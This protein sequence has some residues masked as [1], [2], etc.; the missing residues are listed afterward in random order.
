MTS[1][2]SA[3]PS[4]SASW[5]ERAANLFP[6]AAARHTD[7]VV[8]EAHGARVT[9]ED[10]RSLLDFASGVGVTNV[11]HGHPHVV[12]AIR[13]QLDVLIHGGHNVAI[14]PPYIALAERLIALNGGDQKVY[15]SN[16]GA[17]ALEGAV[18][19]AARATGREG[20]VAF[21]RSF[22][23]RTMMTAALTASSSSYRRGYGGML[24]TVH[25]VDYPAA[26]ANRSS[27]AAETQRCLGE[28]DE[29]FNLII[30]PDEVAAIVIEPIQGE[31]G[32]L[33]A[34]VEFLRGVHARAD[35]HGI[36]VIYDE[37]QS[38]F[39]RSGTMFAWQHAGLQPDVMVLAKG[40]ANGLPLSAIV[41][42]SELMDSWP[43]GAHGGTYGGNPLACVAALAVIDVLE[44]GALDN[45][46]RV[47]AR[48]TAGLVDVAADLP[49]ISDVRGRGLMLGL[50]LRDE[51]HRPATEVVSRALKTAADDGLLALSCGT[52]KNVFRLMPPTTVTMAEADQALTI[53]G[54]SLRQ[55]CATS[56]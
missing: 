46:R 34:P 48:L 40:I 39:G 14:Y 44:S 31:G 26:F 10:G 15:F 36:V 19:L 33:P 6:P 37:I 1:Q 8:T 51:R 25:H 32:Y 54:H 23:G 47:G 3:P 49:L 2:T 13:E 18:K 21:K 38:G 41:A 43:P 27:V 35:Q 20:I 42:R 12:Q 30:A 29:L 50:E 16:S 11:G 7:L 17:E 4:A 53:L 22:H 9:L 52:Q 55:A 28:L 45:A 5:K 56:S 24:P